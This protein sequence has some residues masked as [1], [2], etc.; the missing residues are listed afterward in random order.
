MKQE[1]TPKFLMLARSASKEISYRLFV[2]PT[3]DLAA[4]LDGPGWIDVSSRVRIDNLP[5]VQD[6][7]EYEQGQFTINTL[8]ITIKGI[9]WWKDH[10]FDISS[11]TYV[12]CKLVFQIIGAEDEIT[13]FSGYIDKP[14]SPA[15]ELK[16]ELSCTAY[17]A[18][19][20]GA[21]RPAELISC[22]P[23]QR[24]ADGGGHDGMIMALIDGLAILDANISGFEVKL[25][26]HTIQY[27]A[28]TPAKIS[29]DGGL[30]VTFA[31]GS[32]LTLGNGKTTSEDTERVKVMVIGGGPAEDVQ[33][34]FV[35]VH[36]GDTLPRRWYKDVDVRYLL[37]QLYGDIGLTGVNFDT[38]EMPTFDGGKR[39]MYVDTPPNNS[40]FTD[41]TKNAIESDGT[42]LF[43]AVAEKLYYRN[44]FTGVYTLLGAL[45]A[46]PIE[47]I[48]FNARNNQVWIYGAG[49]LRRFDISNATMSAA[50]ILGPADQIH[51]LS[52]QLVD[53]NYTGTSWRYGLAYTLE[54]GRPDRGRFM[55]VDGVTTA[56]SLVVTGDALGYDTDG[57]LSRFMYVTNA[58]KLRFRVQAPFSTPAYREYSI[59][60]AGVWT[61]NGEVLNGIEDYGSPTQ[62]QRA[63]AYSA[64]EGRIYYITGNAGEPTTFFLKSHTDA[65]PAPT[66]V[67][68][69]NPVTSQVPELYYSPFDSK[70]YFTI[71]VTPDGM[72]LNAFCS[73]SGNATPTV[74]TTGPSCI[75]NQIVAGSDRIYLLDQLTLT[76]QG[77]QLKQWSDKIVV[78][79]PLARF[80]GMSTF[81]AIKKVLN[82]FTLVGTVSSA[83]R[84]FVYRRGD[85]SGTPVT[86]GKRL[87][88]T[89]REASELTEIIDKYP[90]IDLIIIQSQTQTVTY[91]GVE[92]GRQVLSD[93]RTLTIQSDFI[94]DAIAKDVAYFAFQFF[95]TSRS[96][97]QVKCGNV[98]L[99][100]FEPFDEGDVTFETTQIQKTASGP[101]YTFIYGHDGSMG[102]GVLL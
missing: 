100:H 91:D 7:I 94:P 62:L 79:V 9:R 31:G 24:N 23:L 26:V 82:S 51:H 48:M 90:G 76:P 58:G 102:V 47:K 46:D 11:G 70:I 68:D 41:W 35:V 18:E 32:P 17:T 88:I 45:T 69:L 60:M 1:V 85:D 13:I 21:R 22:Q 101:I 29:F 19:D 75:M 33:D 72:N 77:I 39:L 52:M 50:I 66:T 3:T 56:V 34:E 28:G 43:V 55:F 6:D 57:I 96:L 14:G 73:T 64:S 86:T 53:F 36:A 65:S 44:K 97:Y 67:W 37:A 2:R 61:D 93:R 15:V 12:E 38:L 5:D 95:K 78:S 10:V 27:K 83:K 40:G 20:I 71:D 98:P 63:V 4:S 8:A 49:E 59:I 89:V 74:L 92:F 84:A 30:E 87:T 81:D 25:G 42:G 99:F 80:T 16:D 54:N